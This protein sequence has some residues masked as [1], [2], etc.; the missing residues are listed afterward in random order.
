MRPAIPDSDL[1]VLHA[2]EQ[3]ALAGL[4]L[5]FDPQVLQIL[6]DVDAAER[7]IEMLKTRISE[8]VLSRLFNIA[9]SVH[10]GHLLKGKVDNFY[11]VVSRL[12][13][14]FTKTLVIILAPFTLVRSREAEIV[15]ARCFA[16]SVL[17]GKIL[18]RE[19]GLR[20]DDAKRVE[21]GGLFCEIGKII[22]ILHQEHHAETWKQPDRPR[23]FIDQYHSY[24]GEKIIEKFNLPDYL[25][26]MVRIEH[27]ML[28]EDLVTL[29]GIVRLAWHS[30]DAS[31]RRRGKLV[32]GSPMPD[33]GK[34]VVS[35][36]G[37]L[38]L[39]Q[40]RAIGLEKYLELIPTM[41][42][43]QRSNHN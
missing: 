19:F 29:P 17:A 37:S 12:G 2:I 13:M 35:T 18:A 11:Q 25:R 39:E 31:F 6:E 26:D 24:F 5:G 4:N 3:E 43:G 20:E 40:F 23:D 16:T 30:V 22:M 33:Q 10:Y 32:I 14:S 36:R 7:D 42:S 8:E 21:L 1:E 41:N 28:G 9:N 38:I 27:L 15:F 34:G